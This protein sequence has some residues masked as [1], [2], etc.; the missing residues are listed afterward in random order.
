MFSKILL[1]KSACNA[2]YYIVFYYTVLNCLDLFVYRL[3]HFSQNECIHQLLKIQS[4]KTERSEEKIFEFHAI[5]YR[6]SDKSCSISKNSIQAG[7]SIVVRGI[8]A[9]RNAAEGRT[10]P[11][12]R[13]TFELLVAHMKR[14]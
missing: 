14:I 9:R 6:M 7:N 8:D 2:F 12:V 3:P 13:M 10:C 5:F 1:T 4:W 11:G